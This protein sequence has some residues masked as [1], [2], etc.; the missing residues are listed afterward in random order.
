[1]SK[2]ID[3][4]TVPLAP[5]VAMTLCWIPPGRFRMGSRDGYPDEQPVQ[6]VEIPQGFWLGQTPVTQR[7]YAAF[8]PEHENGFH[9]KP[10][11]P[12]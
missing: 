2:P 12:A 9:G 4:R 7:Q 5:G 8:D 11:H 10:E 3:T 1:M 6:E